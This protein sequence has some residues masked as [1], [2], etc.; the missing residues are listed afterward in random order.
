[1]PIAGI[2]HIQGRRGA[3]RALWMNDHCSSIHCHKSPGENSQ[4]KRK[5]LQTSLC[6]LGRGPGCI[7]QSLGIGIEDN[8]EDLVTGERLWIT[9][10]PNLEDFIDFA[11]QQKT[12][13]TCDSFED[14]TGRPNMFAELEK[15]SCTEM[16][17]DPATLVKW[18]QEH[19]NLFDRQT[20][21]LK[22]RSTVRIGVDYA[23]EDAKLSYRFYVDG[24]PSVSKI[25][26]RNSARAKK[27]K[28]DAAGNDLGHSNST[29]TLSDQ[30][31][32]KETSRRRRSLKLI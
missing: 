8:G 29:Q 12:K 13:C 21:K 9:E 26:S 19:L 27:M 20:T 15:S 24:D 5:R 6:G 2:D 1:M 22:I 14:I 16:S 18:S 17:I 31:H 28:Y 7:T 30:E 25:P 23:G 4:G 3:S 10:S 11:F 32:Q